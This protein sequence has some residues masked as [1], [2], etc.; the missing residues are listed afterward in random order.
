[1]THE[2]IIEL[3]GRELDAAVHEGVYGVPV[4]WVGKALIGHEEPIAQGYMVPHYSRDMD[5]AWDVVLRMAR[6]GYGMEMH[7]D[8]PAGEALPSAEV[9]FGRTRTDLARNRC[10]ADD[11]ATAICRA[12]LVALWEDGLPGTQV[13]FGG[14]G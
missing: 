3:D 2:Q 8:M 1:M 10:S 11:V 12:A 13:A 4:H 5:W 9:S 7:V 6:L 14:E